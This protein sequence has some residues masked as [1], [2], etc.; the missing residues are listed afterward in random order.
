MVDAGNTT[1]S[2]VPEDEVV[3]SDTPQITVD[4]TPSNVISRPSG[5]IVRALDRFI[6]VANVAISDEFESDPSTY[7]GAVNNVDADQ[8]VKAIK[9][10]LELMYSNNVWSLVKAL[11]DIKPID[12][13]WVYKRKRGEDGKVETF[14]ARLVTKGFTQKEGIDYEET[15]SPIA[16]LKSIQ[17]LLAIAAHFDYEIWQMDVKTAFLNWHFD[18]DIYMMQLDGFIA[19]N[20]E[21][22]VCK[23]QRSIYGLKQASRSWNV[24]FDETIK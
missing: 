18:E 17:L 1:S 23:L 5:K 2:K 8:W 4:E 20:Q 19:N 3:V 13:K 22:M 10:E 21:D 15:F 14:K 24:R 12:C 7:N 16:M 11:N 6:G 9:S